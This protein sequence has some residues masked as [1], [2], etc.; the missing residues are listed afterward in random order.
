MP[1]TQNQPYLSQPTNQ[2]SDQKGKSISN[3]EKVT[4]GASGILLIIII[5]IG[6]YWFFT[7]RP[8]VEKQVVVP[9]E[10]SSED[11]NETESIEQNQLSQN[12]KLVSDNTLDI[13]LKHPPE[14]SVEINEKPKR[15]L[16]LGNQSDWDLENY[17]EITL[18][19]PDYTADILE[20]GGEEIKSGSRIIVIPF[21]NNLSFSSLDEVNLTKIDSRDF[22]KTI[23]VDGQEARRVD[24][25]LETAFYFT[26][27]YVLKKGKAFLIIR[28]YLEGEKSVY[29]EI[30]K[31][32]LGNLRFVK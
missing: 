13:E 16:S 26:E 27:V 17:H 32:V 14:W 24:Y 23:F 10:K 28:N 25:T 18:V 9:I 31:G 11:S 8:Q 5:L 7:L 20:D 6:L 22:E 3:W 2:P 4:I 30:F 21:K 12:W 29:E 1:S 19:S 15:F